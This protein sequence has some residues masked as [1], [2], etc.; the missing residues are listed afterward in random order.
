MVKAEL[1]E[2][3]DPTVT[4]T[5]AV[6]ALAIKLAGILTTICVELMLEGVRV[7]IW[8]EEL[9]HFTVAPEAK[10]VPFIVR[11]KAEPPAVVEDGLKLEMVAVWPMVNGEFADVCVPT[12]TATCAVPALAIKLAGMLTT[13]CV[14]LAPEGVRVVTW[15]EELVHFTVAPEAKPVPVIVRLK[16]G[17]CAVAEE[18]LIFVIVGPKPL[19]PTVAFWMK[20]VNGWLLRLTPESDSPV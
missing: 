15:P 11:L 20:T 13:I 12:V 7:V 14:E 1:P 18:G 10:P 17:P 3:T 5:C 8:P 4:A 9:V 6:P 16:E 19:E 2:V